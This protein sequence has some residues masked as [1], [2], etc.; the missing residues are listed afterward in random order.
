[1][2]LFSHH[3]VPTVD[4]QQEVRLHCNYCAIHSNNQPHTF[5]A[6]M[7]LFLSITRERICVYWTLRRSYS[8]H[9]I[10]YQ[11]CAFSPLNKPHI[12]ESNVCGFS[13]ILTPF[14]PVS[15]SR[16]HVHM[17]RFRCGSLK[18][19]SSRTHGHLPSQPEPVCSLNQLLRIAQ[20]EWLRTGSA[21]HATIAQQSNAERI[22]TKEKQ[23]K[24]L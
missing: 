14:K 11:K 10:I 7:Q 8:S 6:R 24:K 19:S 21:I 20:F 18:A 3:Q 16:L 22:W 5:P 9:F 1:M 13:T 17:F 12:P 23:E 15:G 4:N 2:T